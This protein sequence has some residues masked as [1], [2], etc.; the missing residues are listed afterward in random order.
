[1]RQF[2]LAGILASMF[3]VAILSLSVGAAP[4]FADV[5][6]CGSTITTDTTLTTDLLGC[7]GGLTVSGPV[8]LDLG[9]HAVAGTGGGTGITASDGATIRNGRVASFGTG[10]AI[11]LGTGTTTADGL[12]V[13]GNGIGVLVVWAPG[14]GHFSVRNSNIRS[15]T[16]GIFIASLARGVPGDVTGNEIAFNSSDGI[17]APYAEPITYQDNNVSHNGGYGIYVKDATSQFID[18]TARANGKDGIYVTDSYGVFFPYWFSGNVA[19]NNGGFGIYFDGILTS[20]NPPATVDGGDNEAKH[21]GNPLQCVGIVCA[22]NKG[23]TA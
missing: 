10:V 5:I 11:V 17:D 2:G 22:L 16:E 9:G 15:N 6:A 8:T 13:R 18:D 4:S 20:E 19:D 7:A 1:M 23:S 12:V 21:N 3:V 14:G